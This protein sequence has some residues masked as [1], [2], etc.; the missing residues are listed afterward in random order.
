M[1]AQADLR[2]RFAPL[3]PK[4]ERRDE[5]Y[6]QRAVEESQVIENSVPADIATERLLDLRHENRCARRLAGVAATEAEHFLQEL[7]VALLALNPMR[8]SLNS[9]L[10]TV[11]FR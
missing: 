3:E 6:Q 8:R 4:L 2:G 11:S 10:M 1:I 7:L 5:A 9:P